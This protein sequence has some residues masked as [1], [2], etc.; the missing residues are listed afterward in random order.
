MPD[1]VVTAEQLGICAELLIFLA[2]YP[3]L[4]RPAPGRRRSPESWYLLASNAAFLVVMLLGLATVLW[5]RHWVGRD[6]VRQAAYALIVAVFG[7]QL[8]LLW[9]AVKARREG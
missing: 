9:V 4:I 3:L 2:G 6:V 8:G 7:W 1:W 5:G